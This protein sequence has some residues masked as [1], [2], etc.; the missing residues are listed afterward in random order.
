MTAPKMVKY[1]YVTIKS[2]KWFGG[3]F[4]QHREIIDEYAEKGYRYVGYIP[5]KL[6]EHGR[7]KEMDLIFESRNLT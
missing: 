1:E 6:T 2:E 3:K 5:I 4:T 7:F